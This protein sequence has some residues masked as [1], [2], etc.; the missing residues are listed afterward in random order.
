MVNTKLL[1]VCI[2]SGLI[3]CIGLLFMTVL[4]S[5]Y[6]LTSVEYLNV[7]YQNITPVI[8][9]EVLLRGEFTSPDNYLGIIYIP[10]KTSVQQQEIPVVFNLYDKKT[11]NIVHSH[12]YVA[13][14]FSDKLLFP[15]GIPPIRT[16]RKIDY[17]FEIR[18]VNASDKVGGL[19]LDPS[20]KIST[21]HLFDRREMKRNNIV[22]FVTAKLTTS[23]ENVALWPFLLI[24]LGSATF[25][26]VV[27]IFVRIGVLKA[28]ERRITIFLWL[29]QILTLSTYILI[30]KQVNDAFYTL[31]IVFHLGISYL[32]KSKPKIHYYWAL[33][34]LLMCPIFLFFSDELRAEK[35][36]IFVFFFLTFGVF[37]EIYLEVRKNFHKKNNYEDTQTY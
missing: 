16:S 3:A 30:P 11:N 21:I 31:W 26:L 10:F 18:K 23:V 1:L 35:A 20:K 32:I 28:I 27:Q 8:K 36:A 15:I 22:S 29:V 4:N 33:A 9:N 24:L 37:Q 14:N 34:S 12:E 19:T 6:G 17:I 2:T 5:P 7:S 13:K 25:P